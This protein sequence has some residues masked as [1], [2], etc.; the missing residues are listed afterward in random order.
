MS[1]NNINFENEGQQIRKD[2]ETP[3]AAIF[4]I[5]TSQGLET[6]TFPGIIYVGQT[7][8]QYQIVASDGQSVLLEK[9][10]IAGLHMM[11]IDTYQSLY[12][13]GV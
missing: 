4:Y 7:Q 8:S 3:F 5:N 6:L 1:N 10:N 2:S 9:R 13:S 12:D 11:D